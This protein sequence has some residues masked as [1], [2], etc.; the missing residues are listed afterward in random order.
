MRIIFT[1]MISMLFVS[2][3]YG[4]TV[5]IGETS[6]AS[7][8]EAI[9]AASGNDTII[10]ITGVHS[11]PIT[12]AKNVVIRG[13]DPTTDIIEAAADQATATI[14]T[15]LIN[16]AG[17]A[18]Y[19]TLENL[20]IRNGNAAGT[21]LGGGI[22][23][24]RSAGKVVLNNLV[25]DNNYS[26]KN[27]GGIAARA[28]IVDINYCTIKNNTTAGMGAGIFTGT[29]ATRDGVINVSKSLIESNA[30]V[31]NG[32]G[33]TVEGSLSKAMYIELNFEN[34]IIA[35]NTSDASG[36][37]AFIKGSP[38]A[39]DAVTTASV[40]MNHVT[41]ANNSSTAT[42]DYGICFF[43]VA[44]TFPKFNIYNSIAKNE[45]FD[46]TQFAINFAKSET[47]DLVNCVMGKLNS[48][49][50]NVTNNVNCLTGKT[51]AE[52][53]LSDVLVDKGGKV[54]VLPIEF[55][56]IAV[57]RAD[58]AN[59][60]VLSDDILDAA[61]NDEK[62]DAGA[63][64]FNNPTSL[65][66]PGFEEGVAGWELSYNDG[67]TCVGTFTTDADAYAGSKAAKVSI[68]TTDAANTMRLVS[69]YT[70]DYDKDSTYKVTVYAK[71]VPSAGAMSFTMQMIP[72]NED[73]TIDYGAK[74]STYTL[75]NT[76][77]EFVYFWTPKR[78]EYFKDAF[79]R[80][81][82]G[83]VLGD[84]Y[85][86]EVS[87]DRI[88]D[89]PYIADG[90]FEERTL[91][92]GWESDVI[93]SG[94]ASASFS[95]DSDSQEGSQAFKAVV[96]AV[97]DTYT[98]AKIVS[99]YIQLDSAKNYVAS[100]YAKSLSG[101]DTAK[102]TLMSYKRDF[103][104]INGDIGAT[105][106]PGTEYRKYL[107][108]I[109]TPDTDYAASKIRAAVGKNTGTFLFDG[110][111][112]VEDAYSAPAITSKPADTTVFIGSKFEYQIAT[113]NYEQAITELTYKTSKNADWLSLSETGLLSGT[114]IVAE[115][116][117]MKVTINFY[118]GYQDVN[119]VFKLI[120]K[121]TLVFTSTPVT[122]VAVDSLYNYVLE[123][124][125]TGD[126]SFTTDVA[127]DWLSYDATSKTLSGTP[128]TVQMVTVDITYKNTNEEVLQIFT[129]NVVKESEISSNPVEYAFI[130]ELYK[131]QVETAG[132]GDL[133]MET[134]AT[135][136]SLDSLGLIS[137]TPDQI[138]TVVVTL[139]YGDY[140]QAFSIEVLDE[141]TII[142]EAVV[143]AFINDTYSYQVETVGSGELVME[144]DAA[145]LSIDSTG[146]ISGTP[147]KLEKTAVTLTFANDEQVFEIDVVNSAT[148]TSTA[149]T[150]AYIDVRYKYE[151][152]TIGT[153]TL[154]LTTDKEATW[155]T[156][157]SL[158]V[159]S[160][161][162]TTDETIQVELSFGDDTQS[163]DLV[164]ND[165]VTGIA[166]D[167][168]G[169]VSI[170]PNP[171]NNYLSI[172]N[173]SNIEQIQLFD[174]RGNIVSTISNTSSVIYYEL[175]GLDSGIYL[176]RLITESD[177]RTYRIIKE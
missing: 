65:Y 127:A 171:A 110:F 87:I 66:N 51:N 98:D 22:F 13:T 17:G 59:A 145:W 43:G 175:D 76:Y 153:G 123:L 107:L 151:V 167:V 143:F 72:K 132:S 6:Y 35:Y 128:D 60:T 170:Y 158:N 125:G 114:P 58:P 27:G 50:S 131:Y 119:Q 68:T 177:S 23:I 29:N 160:G 169:L 90:G 104:Y 25:V 16:G 164:I 74:S 30:A 117:T 55:G 52:I 54:K 118:D 141:P 81:T 80:F 37:A 12:I 38:H 93:T 67:A 42:N 14:R 36:G 140:R 19:V 166:N 139:T 1:L 2:L 45:V 77:Q 84:V 9:T 26:A 89:K 71:G 174:L 78:G 150:E 144:T 147:S 161:V 134:E 83:D 47:T 173:A 92:F 136:L 138:D 40:N 100:Y 8:T 112:I 48:I 120:I 91:D 103:S 115:G 82:F 20:T 39:T 133:K 62:S 79:V 162:P 105:I 11:E 130:G 4:Q 97:S 24:D 99:H 49:G 154:T 126:V 56:S 86:D 73:A 18:A 94:G 109:S 21:N 53:K 155:L 3:T 15:V 113:S 148:I 5:K 172:A 146:L 88:A 157:D 63:V 75:T 106:V 121:P 124:E 142:S 156:L 152:T 102:M 33:F 168:F 111:S 101:K 46:A 57:D 135:W 149:V 176:L 85:F 69:L 32:G 64:E 116:D 159:L 165:E 70:Q 10:D 137:G 7:I 28:S 41:I 122:S 129:I 163:F 95:L 61:R 44:G 31:G 108:P 34:T 96:D